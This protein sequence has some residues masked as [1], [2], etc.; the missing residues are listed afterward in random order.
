MSNNT[1]HC[2]YQDSKGFL[3]FGTDDGLNMFDGYE[4]SRFYNSTND[5]GSI[6][7]NAVFK[8]K[9]DS[10]GQL[11][12]ATNNGI[13]IY[14][15]DL[16]CFRHIPFI[17][18]NNTILYQDY[19]RDI[20]ED[21]NGDII[22]ITGSEIFIYDTVN[23]GFIRYLD[24]IDEYNDFQKEG[25]R[26]YLKDKN[27][28]I[29]IGTD[30]GGLNLYNGK[31]NSFTHFKADDYNVFGLNNNSVRAI[32]EDKQGGKNSIYGNSIL[33]ITEDK[34]GKIYVGGYLH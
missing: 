22:I 19:V 25:L 8:V 26:A 33:T 3:W 32:Y 30:G 5:S 23:S 29:W 28:R 21:D 27:N 15:R 12:M 9:E 6:A 16:L 34:S 1:V 31:D 10:R 14:D 4:F 24:N 13:D 7:G 17:Q 20:I 11:W 2:V 18:E